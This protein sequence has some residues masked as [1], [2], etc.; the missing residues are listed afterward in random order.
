MSFKVFDRV[1]ETTSTTGSGTITLGGAAYGFQSFSDVLSSGDTT[2]YSIVNGSSWETGLGTYADNTLSRDTVFESSNSGNLIDLSATSDIYIT[3]PA[4]KSVYRNSNDQVVITDSGIR[5]SDGS[6]QTIASTGAVSYNWVVAD[7]LGNT[8]TVSTTETIYF[9][10]V[11][12][13]TVSLDGSIIS[14]SGGSSSSYTAGTGLNLSGTEFSIDSTVVQ[15][16]DLAAYST[17]SYVNTV[18]GN[19]QSEIS[20]LQAA[21]GDYAQ[22]GDNVSIFVNDAGYLT[23]HPAVSAA[24]SSNNSGRT[25]IQDLLFDSYGHVTGVA[26]G[27]EVVE[28]TDTTYTAGTGLTLSGTEFNFSATSG[29][30]PDLHT[31]QITVGTFADAR[32]SQSSVTQHSGALQITESQIVD[33]GSYLTSE[34]DT[35]SSVTARGASTSDDVTFNGLVTAGTGIE[36][37]AGIPAS[38]TNKLYNVAGSLYFNGAIVAGGGGGGSDWTIADGNGNSETVSSGTTIYFSGVDN[39]DVNYSSSTNTVS[40]SGTDTTYTAGVGINLVGTEFS[41]DD[42]VIQSGDNIS[43]LVNDSSY[44]TTSYV[45]SASGALQT[46]INQNASDITSVSGLMAVSG[47]NVSI[48]LNDA[49]YLTEHPAISAASSSDNS[50]R[51]YIQ[52]IL[53]DS[54]GHVTGITTETETFENTDT[55]YTAGTGLTLAGTEFN[56]SA[57]SG[58]IPDLHASQITAGTFADARISQSSVTQHSGAL[59]ITESQ[60]VDLGTYL[61]SESDTLSSVTARGA[62]TSDA[63]TF[64]GLVTVSTGIEITAGTP[65][66]TTNKLYNVGGSLYFNGSEVAGG[67]GGGTNWTIADGNGNS[68]VIQSGNTVYFSG[69]DLLS[70]DYNSSVNVMSIQLPE[71]ELTIFVSPTDADAEIGAGIVQYVPRKNIEISSVYAHAMVAPSGAAAVFDINMSGQTIMTSGL[72]IDSTEVDSTT[73]ANQPVIGTGIIPSGTELSFDI[74][75]VGSPTAGQGYSITLV[76][77]EF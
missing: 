14:I 64:N 20:A 44:S 34:S 30:I 19:L 61:T 40:I 39:I 35:L 24:S 63:L 51:T 10:G 8:N 71:E 27:T 1:K 25:Y 23:E 62:T 58:E 72:Q 3:Y 48:F 46:Q 9:S 11:D 6:I 16:G 36:L 65:A 2:F 67:G 55:T 33:L 54:N 60:I 73:A 57:S 7:G 45:D 52:D 31:S 38:T 17:T 13:T 74:D 12:G 21:S 37:Q 42:T 29:E 69:V 77:R 68:E 47:D 22:S 53:L 41:I 49:G 66:S 75:Q 15:T 59:Q 43:L 56:F 50:G 32:I 5:F 4:S 28:N 70:V 18:S 26:T 76:F